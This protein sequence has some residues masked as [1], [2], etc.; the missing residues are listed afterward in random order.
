MTLGTFHRAGTA[1]HGTGI[2]G[3]ETL[4]ISGADGEAAGIG[5]RGTGLSAHMARG[6]LGIL[7]SALI[8][9][10][11]V[12]VLIRGDLGILSVRYGQYTAM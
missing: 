6:I 8:I 5:I 3:T 7:G 1:T 12:R 10:V 9:R 2:L 4:G 11:G